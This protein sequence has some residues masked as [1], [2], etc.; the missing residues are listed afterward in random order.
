MSAD[1]L[2]Q[3]LEGAAFALSRPLALLA[4]LAALLLCRTSRGDVGWGAALLGAGLLFTALWMPARFATAAASACLAI[5][6]ACLAAAWAANGPARAALVFG[7]GLCAGWSAQLGLASAA[8]AI[9]SAAALLLVHV[10]VGLL[11]ALAWPR[12]PA[13]PAALAVRVI[14]SWIAAVGALMAAL[15]ATGRAI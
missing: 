1:A 7:A 2:S 15:W 12:L 5:A 10:M 11:L 3:A 4:L 14:G 6:G 8:E 13:G 9:G